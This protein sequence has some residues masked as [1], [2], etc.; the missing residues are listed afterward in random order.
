MDAPS[1]PRLPIALTLLGAL[2][3]IALSISVTFIDA[4]VTGWM[5]QALLTYAAV[6]LS[7]LGGI[8]WGF[9][10]QHAAHGKPRLINRLYLESVGLSL[11]AWGTLF[12]P[13]L[14]QRLL[15]FAFLFALAW[16]LE[17][18]L[19]NRRLI[20]LWYFNL[21]SIITPIVVVAMYVAYFSVI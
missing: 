16:G 15:S 14:H 17:S 4:P 8:R 11:A 5:M 20:P 13:E 7:F 9:A 10:L 19:Y 3:F 6:I 18:L 21:R 1:A 12:L 2:P